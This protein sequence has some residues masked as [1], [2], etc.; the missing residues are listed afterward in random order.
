MDI[1]RAHADYE[2]FLSFLQRAAAGRH[3][4]IHAFVLMTNHVHLIATPHH[5]TSVPRMMQELG[6]QYVRFFNS[7]YQ[8]SGTLWNSR[9]KAFLLD[10]ETYW[11]TCLRYVE[12]NP[13][14][15]GIVVAPG[16][17]VWS[18]YAAHALGKWTNW[19]TPHHLYIALG[20]TAYERQLAY[21]AIC[22][23]P[24]TDDQLAL[25][26]QPVARVGGVSDTPP[27][28]VRYNTADCE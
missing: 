18:S 5:R 28:P 1:F 16:E 4:S 15:A 25:S 12:Q 2:V 11:L 22:A 10:S 26:R 8:R 17:Y 21:R 6:V 19:L 14:R 13:V 24:L 3:V 9:Y 7:K 23:T 20:Q 27:T